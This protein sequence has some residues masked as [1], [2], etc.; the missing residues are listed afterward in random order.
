M[1]DGHRKT[2]PKPKT[3]FRSSDRVFRMNG[4]WYFTAREGEHG[5]FLSEAAADAELARFVADKRELEGFQEEREEDAE[6]WKAQEAAGEMD[7]HSWEA[8][9]NAP[10]RQKVSGGG[11]G[12]D[13][14][15]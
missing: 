4:E 11:S 10:T 7:C 13:F 9:P 6:R 3:Y 2:D 5:P 15:V 8:R 12:G 1:S 14:Y